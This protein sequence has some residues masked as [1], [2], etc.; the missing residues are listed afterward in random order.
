MAPRLVTSGEGITLATVEGDVTF[1]TGME[2]VKAVA[3]M[4][5]VALEIGVRWVEDVDESDASK[6]ETFVPFFTEKVDEYGVFDA[7]MVA[8]NQ[9]D[10]CFTFT[11]D[12]VQ[13]ELDALRPI[14]STIKSVNI[15]GDTLINDEC[16]GVSRTMVRSKVVFWSPTHVQVMTSSTHVSM[17]RPGENVNDIAFG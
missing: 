9:Y 16:C 1:V 14:A 2:V 11:L 17:F 4:E 5:N 13:L 12:H 7:A 6:H 8:I 15:P 3:A 10:P